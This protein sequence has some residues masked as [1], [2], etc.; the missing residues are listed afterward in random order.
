MTGAEQDLESARFKQAIARA[1]LRRDRLRRASYALGYFYGCCRNI[2]R[3]FSRRPK[4]SH[5]LHH[6]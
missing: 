6:L 4:P 2:R 1:W 5:A 3:L